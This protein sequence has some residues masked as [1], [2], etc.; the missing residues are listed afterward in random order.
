MCGRIF[1]SERAGE[2]ER[3]GRSEPYQVQGGDVRIQP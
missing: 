1:E 2:C 3:S